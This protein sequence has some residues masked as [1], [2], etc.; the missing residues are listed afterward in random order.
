MAAER[1]HDVRVHWPDGT[2]H[3]DGIRGDSP[4][5]ALD[6]ARRNWITENPYQQATRIE[7]LRSPDVT[8]REPEQEADVEPEP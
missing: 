2:S 5:D 1:W 4:D 6:N 3:D 8:P 7:Y